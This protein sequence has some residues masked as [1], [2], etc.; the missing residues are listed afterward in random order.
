MSQTEVA[1]TSST[2]RSL[3]SGFNR[4]WGASIASNLADGLGRTAVP[5]LATTLT[6]DPLL[7][8]GVSALAF[9]PWLLFGVLAGVIA[10]RVD[11]R[12][13]MAA[14][15]ATRVVAASGIAIAIATGTLTIWLL[16]VCI[17]V[18][19]IGE[20]VYDNATTAVV[21]SLV[22]KAGLE[23]ANSRM[24]AAEMV[25]QNFIA[26]PIAG[27]LFAVSIII[28]MLS[29]AAGFLVAAAL[30]L[31][32]PLAAGRAA[33]DAA[34]PVE[35]TTA[36][37]DIREAVSFLMHHRFLRNMML[38][39]SATGS[40]L[41]FAQA[42]SVL[43]FL[44][45]LDVPIA[46]IGFVTAGIGA[47]ALV[48]ALTASSLVARF[49][50]GAIMLCA[51]I[52][53]GAGL[54]ATGLAPNIY[55]AVA[56]YAMGACGVATWNVPWGALRQ[57]LVPGRLLGRVTG[58]NRTIVWGLFPI[59][60]LIGGLVARADLRLPF[61]VGG[62]LIVVVSLAA[63]RLLLSASKQGSAASGI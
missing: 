16:Y 24:Q 55:V 49:G 18:F 26:T 10:D 52:V 5:L 54:V 50:R 36:G 6:K 40:L 7:I 44:E 29:T 37:A 21:P 32:L 46:A 28:P 33:R 2:S 8:A 23:R 17:L 41:A 31:T 39:T 43:F 27:L 53:A 22:G 20:T 38:V 59:A 25:V 48:G 42:S 13:A 19:G 11:R 56:A 3:G 51:C 9:V 62:A 35:R 63:S 45:T 30:A 58:L 61:L 14:A 60:G 15:N 4:L 12:F 47:G 57:D 34:T 1:P